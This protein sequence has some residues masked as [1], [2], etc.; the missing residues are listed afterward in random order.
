MPSYLAPISIAIDGNEANKLERVGSNVYAHEIIKNLEKITRLTRKSYFITVLLA[1]KPV[2]DMPRE[3]MGFAYKIIKPTKFWTQ[4][5]LPLH[6]FLHKADYDVFYTPGHYAPR[7]SAVPYV[8]SIMDLAFLVYPEQFRK[9][10]LWQLRS[11]T[12]YSVKKAKAIVTISRFS[13][14]EIVKH[15]GKKSRD[16]LIAYPGYEMTHVKKN[17]TQELKLIEEIGIKPPYFLYVGTLQP[18]KNLIRLVEAYENYLDQTEGAS[19]DK[20][21]L[22]LAG[23]QGW[24]VDELLEKIAKSPYKDQII[25]T[26]FISDELKSILMRYCLANF[27]IGLYEGFGIPTLEALVKNALPVVANNSSL[28]EVI[29]EAGIEVDPYNVEEITTTMIN[30]VSGG[31]QYKD[32]YL[33]KKNKH[34]SRFDYEKS[35]N[36]ILSLLARVA[37]NKQ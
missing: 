30:I 22:V 14:N 17:Q 1:D 15:Y 32:R 21:K 25:L 9:S 13:K 11:W 4:W 3:R 18:R 6:L 33:S 36:Q 37:K 24:L 35:A 8:S 2:S 23:K 27:N 19:S 10:D 28:P 31:A 7:Y 12:A 16:I 26:G 34:L 5:A 29:G 20:V